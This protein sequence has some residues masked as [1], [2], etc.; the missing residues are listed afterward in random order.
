[1]ALLFWEE[2]GK[3]EL[4]T[5]RCRFYHAVTKISDFL[6]FCEVG[7]GCFRMALVLSTMIIFPRHRLKDR[8]LSLNRS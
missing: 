1:M 6:G 5:G 2:F 8:G 7:R 3:A 4:P